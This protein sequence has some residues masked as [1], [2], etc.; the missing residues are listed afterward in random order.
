MRGNFSQKLLL[1]AAIFLLAAGVGV[2]AQKKTAIA[3]GNYG[4]LVLGVDPEGV[5]TGYFMEGTGDDGNGNP[6][7]TC[8]FFI[9]GEK[10]KDGGFDVETWYPEDPADVIKGELKP[11]DA[12]GKTGVNLHL[13]GEHGGCWNVAPMLKE[14]GGVDFEMTS[15]GS[16]ESIRVVSPARV[17]LFKSSGAKAPQKIYLVKGDVVRILQT[18]G[19]R[20]EISYTND[21]GRTTN[22]WME[23]G[24]FFPLFP[25]Q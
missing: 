23:T 19:D 4:S 18:K 24:D 15:A 3:S 5:L 16:W 10:R 6:R 25:N 22:G 13:D 20:A 17:Y 7:F 11:A 12:G 2:R 1:I 14:D 21:K 9:R 8:A